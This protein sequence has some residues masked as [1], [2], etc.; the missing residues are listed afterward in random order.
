MHAPHPLLH[1][2]HA[3]GALYVPV[4][5]RRDCMAFLMVLLEPIFQTLVSES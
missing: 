1:P 4:F 3:L 5:S 2:R